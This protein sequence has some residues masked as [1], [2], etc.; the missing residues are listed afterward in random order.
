MID[1]LFQG[2][3]AK[4]NDIILRSKDITGPIFPFSNATTCKRSSSDG[5][6][7][8]LRYGDIQ[9]IILYEDEDIPNSTM[10]FQLTE[11]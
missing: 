2:F 9:V 7:R 10:V 1:A 6:N 3:C 8:P 5:L 11:Q 4:Q